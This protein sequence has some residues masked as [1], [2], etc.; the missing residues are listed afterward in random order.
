VI[1]L[2]DL[3]DLYENARMGQVSAL[4]AYCA[5]R[6]VKTAVDCPWCSKQLRSGDAFEPT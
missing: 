6:V 3:F 5:R 4:Q 2:F 1:D